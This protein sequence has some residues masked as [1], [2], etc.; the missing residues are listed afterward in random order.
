MQILAEAKRLA[1]EYRELTDRPLGVT[2][3]VAEF[4]AARLLGLELALVR[5]PGFDALEEVDGQPRRL[6]IKGRC[7]PSS[8]KD[9]TIG[10]IKRNATWDAILVVLLD[11]QL[12]AVAI[13]EADRQQVLAALDAPGS[14]ARNERGAL[15][16]SKIKS[17]GRLRWSVKPGEKLPCVDGTDSGPR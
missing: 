3:E 5:Q 13:F 9:G 14:K 6:Q 10:A 12:E 2:A 1:R 8:A 11:P 16:I 7:L 15:R 4:E 17:I